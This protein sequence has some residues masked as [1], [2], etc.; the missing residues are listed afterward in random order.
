MNRYKLVG[1]LAIV[2]LCAGLFLVPGKREYS[3]ML[4]KDGLYNNA[5]RVIEDQYEQGDR[6]A[7]TLLNMFD[8]YTRFG[9]IDKATRTLE[10]FVA[11]RPK[12]VEA[13]LK[14]AKQYRAT[15]NTKAYASTL[16]RVLQLTP[17]SK[18]SQALLGVYRLQGDVVREKTVLTRMVKAKKAKPA[19]FKRL[20]LLLASQGDLKAA[21]E[22]LTTFDK[23]AGMSEQTPRLVLFQLLLDL[24]HF[25]EAYQKA[26]AWSQKWLDPKITQSLVDRMVAAGQPEFAMK[27]ASVLAGK[28][29]ASSKGLQRAERSDELIKKPQ[30]QPRY[31]KQSIT[32]L[33]TQQRSSLLKIQ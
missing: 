26:E 13:L 24:G 8:L 10:T 32:D 18:A 28:D 6:S 12:D 5:L 7:N 19:H 2:A 27:L 1:S 11:T 30:T 31:A 33:R 29:D 22:M 15:Y 16:E 14:L 3:T 4:K 21:R 23:T 25:K 20:G 17:S 9:Q